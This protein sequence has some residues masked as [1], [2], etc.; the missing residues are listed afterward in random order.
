MSSATPGALTYLPEP[1]RNA[2]FESSE[3]LD[4]LASSDTISIVRTTAASDLLRLVSN[5]GAG[6][7]T[8]TPA[9]AAG[10]YVALSFTIPETVPPGTHL[11]LQFDFKTS[12]PSG[13]LI[14]AVFDGGQR[15]GAQHDVRAEYSGGHGSFH[16]SLPVGRARRVPTASEGV[17]R[18]G[19]PGLRCDPR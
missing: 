7:V 3:P 11:F 13:L 5:T 17:R 6:R 1:H 12:S 2:H 15:A 14:P 16:C 10:D 19:R 9:V 18:S 8:A 4:W